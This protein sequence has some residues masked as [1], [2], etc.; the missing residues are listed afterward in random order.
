[1]NRP[2][3]RGMQVSR[4]PPETGS[5]AMAIYNKSREPAGSDGLLYITI[6]PQPSVTALPETPL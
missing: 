5:K 2:T 1:V 3:I 4:K 6:C